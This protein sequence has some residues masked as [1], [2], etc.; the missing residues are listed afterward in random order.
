MD[1]IVRTGVAVTGTSW[2]GQFVAI[3]AP[4]GD[5]LTTQLPELES[6]PRIG[7]LIHADNRDLS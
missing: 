2:R 6:F 4:P 5:R 1:M 3:S 7:I